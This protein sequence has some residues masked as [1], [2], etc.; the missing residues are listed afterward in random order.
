MRNY[1]IYFFLQI[2][3]VGLLASTHIFSQTTNDAQR[4]YFRVA[5]S[6]KDFRF[7][8]GLEKKDFKV[9]ENGVE[10]EID[11]LEID[12]A[13][14]SILILTDV[15]RAR[16]SR[17]TGAKYAMRFVADADARNEYAVVAFGNEITELADWGSDQQKIED[18]L[19]KVFNF[20]NRGENHLF[21]DAL[22][23]ARQ[24][25]RKAKHDKKILL[26]FANGWDNL[27]KESFKTVTKDLKSDD[28]TIYS[29]CY[30]P[31]DPP[32]LMRA[33]DG[34][35]A[36]DKLAEISGGSSFFPNSETNLAEVMRLISEELKSRYLLGYVP[37]ESQNKKDWQEVKISALS[38]SKKAAKFSVRTRQGYF[39]N[40]K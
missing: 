33:A 29:V 25:F 19:T 31:D 30:Y 34:E 10:Q 20:R 9:Y 5:V 26:V 11:S 39:R 4:V 15:A 38:G 35:L 8:S 21:Y 17:Q 2:L 6:D 28:T 13:P 3:C 27:S 32:P 40:K 23:L 24:K 37:K 14:A 22:K 36:L 18:A 1:K 12:S 16:V 7:V